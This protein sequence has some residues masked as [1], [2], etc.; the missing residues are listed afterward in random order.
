MVTRGNYASNRILWYG[1][2][3]KNKRINGQE[4]AKKGGTGRKNLTSLYPF[5]LILYPF[6]LVLCRATIFSFSPL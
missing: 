1:E 3:A 2:E 6:I 5:P 4:M